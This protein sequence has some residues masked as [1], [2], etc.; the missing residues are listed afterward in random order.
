MRISATTIDSYRFYRAHEEKV[1]KVLVADLRKENP[2]TQAMMAGIALHKMLELSD[3]GSI[4]AHNQDEFSFEF[5]EISRFLYQ[6]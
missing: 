6:R 2:P 4:V 5:N 3:Q 1:L